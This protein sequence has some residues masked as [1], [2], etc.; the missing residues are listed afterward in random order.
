MIARQQI[1]ARE[2]EQHRGTLRDLLGAPRRQIDNA[3]AMSAEAGEQRI[4][5]KTA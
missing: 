3:V 1:A 4:L 2:A 5:L